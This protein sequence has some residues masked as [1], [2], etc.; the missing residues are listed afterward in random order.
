MS[1]SIPMGGPRK[2]RSPIWQLAI[3]AGV[4]VL[5]WVGLIAV[6]RS[7]AFVLG[8]FVL[9]MDFDNRTE[10]TL[11]YY[12]SEVPDTNVEF[13]NEIKPSRVKRWS[14]ECGRQQPTAFTLTIEETGQRIYS[15]VT[16]CKQW[17]DTGR[18]FIIEET[19]DE[20]VVTDPFGDVTRVR[21]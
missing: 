18:R 6:V 12:S 9:D 13:C 19:E 1:V 20:F 16:T 8:G 15:S 14:P 17:D 2:D 7:D 4:S 10:W 11:C 3:V 21:R 5:A